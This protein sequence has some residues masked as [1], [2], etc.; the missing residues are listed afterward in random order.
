M[1]TKYILITSTHKTE[2]YE[3][4]VIVVPFNT[5]TPL[6]DTGIHTFIPRFISVKY[7]I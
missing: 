7:V 2:E 1:N 4:V 6:S 3:H 5:D